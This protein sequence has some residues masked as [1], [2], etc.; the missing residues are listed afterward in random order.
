MNKLIL[1]TVPKD[2]RIGDAPSFHEMS[3]IIY[4]TQQTEY[5]SVDEMRCNMERIDDYLRTKFGKKPDA[6]VTYESL[7]DVDIC[8]SVRK[9]TDK[10]IFITEDLHLRSLSSLQYAVDS[11]DIVLSRFN[12][13]NDLLGS[14]IN[15]AEGKIR[16]FP[17]HCSEKFIADPIPHDKLSIVHFGQLFCPPPNVDSRLLPDGVN[18][19]RYRQDWHQLFESEYASHYK[20]LRAAPDRLL[21][22]IREHS[23]GFAST[24]F[25]YSFTQKCRDEQGELWAQH[26]TPTQQPRAYL[27]AKFFE[28]PGSG[29]LLLADPAGV[30]DFLEEAGFVENEN[31]IA[32]RQNN[33]RQVM[34]YL[35]NGD[36]RKNIWRIQQNGNDL[37][38]RKHLI[39]SRVSAYKKIIAEAIGEA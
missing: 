23:V 6:V 29:L 18:Q 27:V 38:R 9:M 4:S 31:Y 17:L 33:H 7:L 35:T 2:F 16:S 28:I 39:S 13:I 3:K 21:T 20:Y 19:Y 32:I 14:R 5:I 24:Y 26:N 11:S 25:P 36:N 1:S 15:N 8:N 10:V 30:E 12:I 34:E 37:I 22:E